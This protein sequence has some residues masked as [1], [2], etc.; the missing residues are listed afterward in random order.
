MKKNAP[1]FLLYVLMFLPFLT[2]YLVLDRKTISPA[3]AI[4]LGQWLILIIFGAVAVN[5]KSEEKSKG[6][7]FLKILPITTREIVAAKFALVMIMV[8][9][10]AAYENILLFF[11]SIPAHLLFITR[12]WV[13]V[14]AIG[15]LFLAGL[16]YIVIF[17]FGHAFFAKLLWIVAVPVFILPIII[18][19]FVL[20]KMDMDIRGTLDTLNNLSWLVWT[21]LILLSLCLYYGL[22]RVTVKTKQAARG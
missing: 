19:E 6:Y 4:F 12:I 3:M 14:C 1:F 8:V 16:M 18:Y 9:F 2:L 17:R 10:I 5:E 21:A 7:D 20:L 11:F 15:A 22:M 13:G